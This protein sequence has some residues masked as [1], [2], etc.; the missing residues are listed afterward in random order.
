MSDA[1]SVTQRERYWRNTVE[2]MRERLKNRADAAMFEGIREDKL[3]HG[4]KLTS[5]TLMIGTLSEICYC[6]ET[7]VPSGAYFG[8][9]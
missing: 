7:Q 2:K 8:V 1:S 6:T 5:S 3:Y 9:T 4:L